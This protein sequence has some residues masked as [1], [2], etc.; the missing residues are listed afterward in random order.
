ML[1]SPTYLSPN[2]TFIIYLSSFKRL[3][4]NL[5]SL[6][7]LPFCQPSGCPL[8]TKLLSPISCL[9]VGVPTATST[10]DSRHFS[11]WVPYLEN[12]GIYDVEVF[13]PDGPDATNGAI[14]EIIVRN[15][16]NTI[17]SKV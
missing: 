10:N 1:S 9:N 12:S 2:S 15:I 16:D 8:C 5:Y 3:I 14:Y 11:I 4:P 6:V 17:P 7:S 13:V